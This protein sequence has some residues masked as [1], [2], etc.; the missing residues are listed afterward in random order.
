[1]FQARKKDG[2]W[3]TA[4]DRESQKFLFSIKNEI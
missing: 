4:S 3:L 2:K 1:M